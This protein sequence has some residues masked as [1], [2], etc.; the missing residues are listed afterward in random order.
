[1]SLLLSSIIC[2]VTSAASSLSQPHNEPEPYHTS[3]LSGE[4]WLL[5]LVGGHPDHIHNELGVH[6]ETFN[7]LILTLRSYGHINARSVS[8]E[9]QLAIFLYTCVTGLPVRHVG[10]RF[11]QSN[12]TISWYVGFAN[13]SIEA[14]CLF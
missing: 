9:E 7:N 10:E 2:A 1:M 4:S 6:V 13:R 3:S 8:L 5:E 11:Q 12:G 14:N